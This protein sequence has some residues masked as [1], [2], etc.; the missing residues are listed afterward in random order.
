MKRKAV[1]LVLALA[2]VGCADKRAALMKSVQIVKDG[3]GELAKEARPALAGFCKEVIG[4]CVEEN[5][6]SFELCPEAKRCINAMT[7]V[8]VATTGLLIIAREATLA[9][10]LGKLDEAQKLL[11][12]ALELLARARHDYETIKKAVGG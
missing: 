5:R 3:A 6:R 2:L 7:S 10:Q 8:Q 11:L 12:Q 4:K 9:L 1:A